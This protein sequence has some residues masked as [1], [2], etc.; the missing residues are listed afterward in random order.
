MQIDGIDLRD[1]GGTFDS[2]HLQ[3]SRN[4]MFGGFAWI[5]TFR[6]NSDSSI[7]MGEPTRVQLTV[8]G[9]VSSSKQPAMTLR[10]LRAPHG[11]THAATLTSVPMYVSPLPNHEI[12]SLILLCSTISRSPPSHSGYLAP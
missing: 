10:N 7:Y 2:G 9:E 3:V 8:D 4:S 1:I 12:C 5:S 6:R 11:D